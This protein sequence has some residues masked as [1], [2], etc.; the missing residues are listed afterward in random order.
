M[1]RAAAAHDDAGS[2]GKALL[3]KVVADVKDAYKGQPAR[4][5][6]TQGWTQTRGAVDAVPGSSSSR[7]TAGSR[8]GSVA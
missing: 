2:R 3:L 4:R 7:E 8:G 6:S 5:R 1:R